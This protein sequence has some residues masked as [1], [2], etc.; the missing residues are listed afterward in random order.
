M[1]NVCVICGVRQNQPT[2][3]KGI[4]FHRLPPFGKLRQKWLQSL[5]LEGACVTN[6]TR[7]CSKHFRDGIPYATLGEKFEEHIDPKQRRIP[8]V[9][10]QTKTSLVANQ[11]L[12][13]TTIQ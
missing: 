1:V 5:Q 2:K 8:L 12:R 13:W 3:L 10:V 9:E 4:T 11:S 7:V 6:A